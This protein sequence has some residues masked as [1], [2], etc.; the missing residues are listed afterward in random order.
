MRAR[1]EAPWRVMGPWGLVKSRLERKP[2]VG[3]RVQ[4]MSVEAGLRKGIQ[5]TLARWQTSEL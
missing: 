5:Q 3:E 4:N 1:R 2:W